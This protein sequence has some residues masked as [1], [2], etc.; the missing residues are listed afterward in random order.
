M[1]S[2]L[3]FFLDYLRS[4]MGSS[5]LSINSLNFFPYFSLTNILAAGL[6]AF[7]YKEN[8]FKAVSLT[9]RLGCF[10]LFELISSKALLTTFP[11]ASYKNATE[12][13]PSANES[14]LICSF[15]G[16][17]FTGKDTLSYL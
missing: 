15:A 6:L 1:F 16:G 10:I 2:L 7:K 13:Y 12:S 4:C 11:T 17:I 9:L 8:N 5:H 14:S 3:F